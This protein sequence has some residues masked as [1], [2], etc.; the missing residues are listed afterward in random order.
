[1]LKPMKNR[2]VLPDVG[3]A[4]VSVERRCEDTSP[5]SCG[6]WQ[7]LLLKPLK[8]MG[9]LALLGGEKISIGKG[10]GDTSPIMSYVMRFL[11]GFV[12]DTFENPG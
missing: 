8:D 12:P 4:R 5:M 2:H 10:C 1:M 6:S 11:E 3:G 7:N 9:L